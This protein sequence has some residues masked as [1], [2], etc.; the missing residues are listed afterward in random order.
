MKGIKMLG[1]TAKLS[2]LIQGLRI[3]ELKYAQKYWVLNAFTTPLGKP[4]TKK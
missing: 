1:L 2:D 3:T 4:A